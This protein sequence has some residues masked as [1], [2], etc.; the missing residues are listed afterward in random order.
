MSGLLPTP[1]R[2]IQQWL[3][4]LHISSLLRSWH[5]CPK[6]HSPTPPGIWCM[7]R[8][9]YEWQNTINLPISWARLMPEGVLSMHQ[10]P[11]TGEEVGRHHQHFPLL[12]GSGCAPGRL[13]ESVQCLGLWEIQIRY[14]RQRKESFEQ[15]STMQQEAVAIN[16]LAARG[17]CNADSFSGQLLE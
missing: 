12:S 5:C 4:C 11:C 13:Q 16:L 3:R 14:S 2:C 8:A 6:A 9:H 7:S 17:R 10:S 1:H 15:R